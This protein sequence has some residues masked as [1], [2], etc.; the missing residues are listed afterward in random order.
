MS[1]PV[2]WTNPIPV[3][4]RQ[5]ITVKELAAHTGIGVDCIK[6]IVKGGE[7]QDFIIVGKQNKVMIDHVAFGKYVKA[8]RHI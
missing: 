3:E 8:K 6:S 5:Y 4:K 1:R 7:F 2:G